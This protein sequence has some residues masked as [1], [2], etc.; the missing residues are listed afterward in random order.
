[1][2]S[3]SRQI[4]SIILEAVVIVIFSFNA[5]VIYMFCFENLPQ[6]DWWSSQNADIVRLS[7]YNMATIIIFNVCSAA[8]L[9]LALR[10]KKM[11]GALGVI[12]SLAFNIPFFMMSIDKTIFL[13]AWG[14]LTSLGFLLVFLW[15][16]KKIWL[17]TFLYL[18][19]SVAVVGSLVFMLT[20]KDYITYYSSNQQITIEVLS[21]SA[22]YIVQPFICLG[23]ML[24][25]Y[26]KRF[27]IKTQTIIGMA[28]ALLMIAYNF[29]ASH[30]VYDTMLSDTSVN[31]VLFFCL[32][33]L[34]LLHNTIKTEP[35][36]TV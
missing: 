35:H 33:S 16:Y 11:I 18:F 23:L 5:I 30:F 17:N 28:V 15:L 21:N 24:L 8:F 27:C 6:G 32:Y 2:K 31:L 25:L 13:I 12:A 1:M 4:L 29:V 3:K 19:L 26:D 36:E 14:A 34:L 7:L 10:R 9:A 22:L 20:T